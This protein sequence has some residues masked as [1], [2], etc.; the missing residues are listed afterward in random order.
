MVERAEVRWLG[1]SKCESDQKYGAHKKQ[2]HTHHIEE[3]STTVQSEERLTK[4]LENVSKEEESTE[5]TL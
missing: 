3:D 2:K 1:E 4:I 5:T